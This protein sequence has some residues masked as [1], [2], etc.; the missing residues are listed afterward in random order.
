VLLVQQVLAELV[1]LRHLGPAQAFPARLLTH[2]DKGKSSRPTCSRVSGVAANS[3]KT[4]PTRNKQ[5][6]P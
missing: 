2:A 6:I 4:R 3:F 5:N 1:G